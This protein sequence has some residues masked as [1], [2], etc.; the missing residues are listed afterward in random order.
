M[1]SDR[2]WKTMVVVALMAVI[3]LM[4]VV[5]D[6]PKLYQ[7]ALGKI[8][9]NEIEMIEGIKK[10]A[11]QGNV[12]AQAELGNIISIANGMSGW[13]ESHSSY[14]PKLSS[15]YQYYNTLV[16]KDYLEDDF[17]ALIKNKK[18][19]ALREMMNEIG[20]VVGTILLIFVIILWYKKFRLDE[21]KHIE[22]EQK[23]KEKEKAERAAL[24]PEREKSIRAFYQD[25]MNISSWTTGDMIFNDS[26]KLET[27]RVDV[28]LK[29]K[30]SLSRSLSSM[31]QREADI[32]LYTGLLNAY[33]IITEEDDAKIHMAI[34]YN[35]GNCDKKVFKYFVSQ[36]FA[37][38]HV[39]K[40]EFDAIKYVINL[41][42]CASP[43]T[44]ISLFLTIFSG[45]E[46]K[47]ADS[48]IVQ[49]IKS[50][51][52]GGS[53][54]LSDSDVGGSVFYAAEKNGSVFIGDTETGKRI[55]YG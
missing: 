13:T 24:A 32:L 21:Q 38:K 35:G 23:L 27:Q 49:E 14:D 19:K 53:N 26:V 46:K 4:L 55:W 45:K 41:W 7:F 31:T 50:K 52:L 48:H 9:N 33:D 43:N 39:I 29:I 11:D 28:K 10:S 25:K 44:G 12:R 20:K 17:Y 5:A 37:D 1:V 16:A 47:Y 6:S 3:A 2:I 36:G 34:I 54:W 40:S 42:D 8:S 15:A 30:F 18:E 22:D 51:I